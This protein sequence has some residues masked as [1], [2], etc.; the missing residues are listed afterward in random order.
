MDDQNDVTLWSLDWLASHPLST[1]HVPKG[2]RVTAMHIP[3][4]YQEDKNAGYAYFGNA[5][6]RVMIF[7][8]EEKDFL[9]IELSPINV[10]PP[11]VVQSLEDCV[12][13]LQTNKKKPHRLLIAYEQFGL[14]VFHFKEMKSCHTII[15][16][17]KDGGGHNSPVRGATYNSDNSAIAIVLANGLVLFFKAND[18]SKEP[19]AIVS[20][21]EQELE[22]IRITC[23]EGDRDDTFA[24]SYSKSKKEIAFDEATKE[25]AVQ[26]VLTVDTFL[27]SGKT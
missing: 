4:F 23:M 22:S 11:E 5:D 19:F 10:L 16:N 9:N 14:A 6:G 12:V 24:V 20:V 18:K 1:T 3:T 2:F 25:M 8:L 7:S 27:L 26:E 21:G 13:A 17:Q 15:I